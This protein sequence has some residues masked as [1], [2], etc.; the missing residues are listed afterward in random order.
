MDLRE[1]TLKNTKLQKLYRSKKS[2]LISRYISTLLKTVQVNSLIF[3]C[4]ISQDIRWV[5]PR[6][7]WNI[8]QNFG[9]WRAF[10]HRKVSGDGNQ[11][12]KT[13]INLIFIHQK[14]YFVKK[15]TKIKNWIE[16]CAQLSNNQLHSIVVIFFFNTAQFD[17]YVKWNKIDW[18]SLL[19]GIIVFIANLYA[20]VRR[21]LPAHSFFFANCSQL[22][23]FNRKHLHLILLD[24]DLVC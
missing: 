2:T 19:F 18:E 9:L 11:H 24:L 14:N 5:G 13:W 21:T 15:E 10:I 12:L 3:I 4:S 7:N 1:R 16:K 20:K 8:P 6:T 22:N 17:I 23:R